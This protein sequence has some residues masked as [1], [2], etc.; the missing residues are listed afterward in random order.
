MEL[1]NREMTN[2]IIISKDPRKLVE[3][4]VLA[5]KEIYTPVQEDERVIT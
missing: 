5:T 3:K 1:C 4:I 2:N